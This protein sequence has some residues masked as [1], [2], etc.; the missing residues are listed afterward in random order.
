MQEQGIH[1]ARDGSEPVVRM[2]G[3]SSRDLVWPAWWQ[4]DGERHEQA[5]GVVVVGVESL[6]R[7]V[8]L[9]SKNRLVM[10]FLLAPPY[11]QTLTPVSP[12]PWRGRAKRSTEKQDRPPPLLRAVDERGES[13]HG[14]EGR[15]RST[16]E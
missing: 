11:I 7:R 4:Q 14:T 10:S 2:A 5:S 16:M 6:H 12:D 9:G 8:S 3:R 15:W 1:S 13:D